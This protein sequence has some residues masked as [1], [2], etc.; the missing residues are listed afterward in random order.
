MDEKLR[1]ELHYQLAGIEAAFIDTTKAENVIEQAFRDVG[2][3]PQSEC[4]TRKSPLLK[5]LQRG[6][7]ESEYG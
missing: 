1:R 3:H 5:A 7:W 4:Q 2:W 6:H